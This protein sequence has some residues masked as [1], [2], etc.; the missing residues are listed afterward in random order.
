[1][2][3]EKR[4]HSVSYRRAGRKEEEWEISTTPQMIQTLDFMNLK[5]TYGLRIVPLST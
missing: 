5:Y 4:I 3:H 1:M 2:A